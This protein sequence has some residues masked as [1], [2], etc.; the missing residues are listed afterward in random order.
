MRKKPKAD[1]GEE[2]DGKILKVDI[3]QID[4]LNGNARFVMAVLDAIGLMARGDAVIKGSTL[5]HLTS[6]AGAKM[7]RIKEII[8]TI[9]A[10]SLL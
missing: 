7:E 3:D 4:E 5:L 2:T 9:E 1:I 6:E 10:G 8:S